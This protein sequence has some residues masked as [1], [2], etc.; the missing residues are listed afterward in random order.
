[1]FTNVVVLS[2]GQTVYCG[3]RR[4]MI[5]H[6]AARGYDCPQYMNP[7]EYFLSLV[8][9]DFDNHADVHTLVHLYA[10]SE[11][12]KELS[13]IIE[14]DRNTLQ[15]LPDMEQSSPSSMRQFGVLMYRNT[16]NNIRNPG[17]YWIRLFMYFCLSFMVGPCT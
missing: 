5:A 13:S 12:Y 6:F 16:L 15:Q 2:A 8:N 7:A 1:M 17:I 3:P 10:Q 4:E 14:S 11:S 9:T